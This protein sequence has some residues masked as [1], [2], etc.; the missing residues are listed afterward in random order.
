MTRHYSNIWKRPLKLYYLTL[1][2]TLWS[3]LLFVAK[4]NIYLLLVTHYLALN[5]AIV[6]KKF[7]IYFIE[8]L[9][10]NLFIAKFL[11]KIDLNSG[12]KQ[13]WIKEKY[14]PK[15]TSE[16]IIAVSSVILSTSA[17]Q[18]THTWFLSL[19][20]RLSSP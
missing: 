3:T 11:S 14:I 1:L 18:T 9:F 12:Y 8:G 5:T 20:K 6:K 17:W 10:E 16:L 4:K 2:V 7:L 13:V 15:P 19:L